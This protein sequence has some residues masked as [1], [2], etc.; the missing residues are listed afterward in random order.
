M[1][2]GFAIKG[3]TLLW[4][5]ANFRI[6]IIAFLLAVSLSLYLEISSVEWMLI[7]TSSALVLVSEAINTAIEKTLDFI[8]TEQNPK[9]A[10][11]KDISAAFVLIAAIAAVI[12]GGVV[13]IPK[14]F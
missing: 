4:K 11:I 7:I 12:V 6:H 5:E 8:S 2:F 1:S 14:F 10:Y 13:F 3:L 9:I